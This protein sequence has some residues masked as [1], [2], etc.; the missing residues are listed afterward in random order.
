VNCLNTEAE[1]GENGERTL[2]RNICLIKR[3]D[4][5]DV[6]TKETGNGCKCKTNR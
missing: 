2:A 3:A 1:S 6:K 5:F 4:A